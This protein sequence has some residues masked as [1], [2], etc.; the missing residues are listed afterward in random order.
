MNDAI[1]LELATRWE[2]EAKTPEVQNGAEEFKLHNA[3]EQGEREC[4]RACADTLRMLVGIL[5]A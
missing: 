4:K 1:L 3:K 5:G 2:R